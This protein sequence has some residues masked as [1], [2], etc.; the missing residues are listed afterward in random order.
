MTINAFWTAVNH[1]TS[2]FANIINHLDN[3]IHA[4][5]FRPYWDL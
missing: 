5:G 1:T 3:Q 4:S 2:P